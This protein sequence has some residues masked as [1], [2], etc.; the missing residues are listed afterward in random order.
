MNKASKIFVP[1]SLSALILPTSATAATLG[2]NPSTQKTTLGSQVTIDL[3]ISDLGAGIAP[4]LGEFDV[5]LGFDTD[6][7]AFESLEFGTQLNPVSSAFSFR[8]ETLLAPDRINL[9]E[10]SGQRTSDLIQFQPNSFTLATFTFE[11]V[12]VGTSNLILSDVIVGDTEGLSLNPTLATGSITVITDDVTTVPEASTTI[13]L[14]S[15][16]CVLFGWH[17]KSKNKNRIL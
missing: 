16:G 6:I 15:L 10:I 1:L 13:A 3:V 11:A 12:G 17:C 9:F 14:L 8:G 5:V 4:S 7:I 2:F